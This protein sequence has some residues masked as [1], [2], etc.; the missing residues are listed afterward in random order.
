MKLSDAGP[1]FA[2]VGP[3]GHRAMSCAECE[4]FEAAYRIA[5]DHYASISVSLQK[6][7]GVE[8]REYRKL[9]IQTDVAK[10]VRLRAQKA[11][12]VHREGHSRKT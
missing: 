2:V 1:Q 8:P 5:K 4:A 10:G 12:R 9:K 7:H 11:F 3:F 6:W